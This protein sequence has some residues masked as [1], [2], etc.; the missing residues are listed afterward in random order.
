MGELDTQVTISPWSNIVWK[1]STAIAIAVSLF[2]IWQVGNTNE[3]QDKAIRSIL[4]LADR[5]VQTSQQRT[6]AEK[7]AAHEFYARALEIIHAKPCDPIPGLP[8]S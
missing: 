7:E 5:Q 1:V 3:R 6:P 2:A 8:R 4:C